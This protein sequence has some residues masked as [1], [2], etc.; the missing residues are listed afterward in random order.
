MKRL[1]LIVLAVATLGS[2][3][4]DKASDQYL[5]S[6]SAIRTTLPLSVC[7]WART[8]SDTDDF[9]TVWGIGQAGVDENFRARLRMTSPK[10]E[11]EA[12]GAAGSGSADIPAVPSVN[13]WFQLCCVFSSTAVTGYL[14]GGNKTVDVSTFGPTGLDST[15]IAQ[16]DDGSPD[17]RLDGDAGHTCVYDIELTDQDVATLANGFS[18]LKYKRANLIG[19]YPANGQSPE[20]NVIGTGFNMSLINAPTVDEEPPIPHAIIAP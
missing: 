18:C 5:E 3:D 1:L 11:C 13:T 14:N 6:T 8:E 7:T 16:L 2:R 17:D 12:D 4:F 15:W 20:P 10:I 9:Q 19:Y